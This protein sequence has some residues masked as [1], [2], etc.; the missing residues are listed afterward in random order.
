MRLFPKLLWIATILI[1]ILA[2]SLYFFYKRANDSSAQPLILTAAVIDQP[3]PKAHLVNIAGKLLEDERLR[4]GKVVLVFTKPEC[5]PCDQENEF[6]KTLAGNRKDVNFFYIIP[7]G[8]KSSSLKEA[9]GKYAYETFFDD[10]SRLSRRLQVYQVPIKV[11]LEDG[12]IR[13][14]WINASITDERKAE[15]KGWLSGL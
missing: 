4:R 13:K 11:F 8:S 1:A 12:I 15:F 9:E 14:T 2:G 6:L 10:E 5:P 3:L 7:F